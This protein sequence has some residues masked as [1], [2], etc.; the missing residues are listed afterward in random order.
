MEFIKQIAPHAQK[1]QEKY[2]ILASLV[3]AQA[4]LESNF[5]QSGLAQ[6]GKNLFGI[7]GSYNGQSVTMKTTE[8][9]NGKPYKTDAA[10]RKYPSWVESL[11]D[12]AQLYTNGVSW[13]KNKY[14]SIIGETNYVTACK[15][16]QECGYATDPNYAA[17]LI[18]IIEKYE[19]HKYDKVGNKKPTKPEAAAKKE[20]HQVYT[21]KKGDTLSEIAQKYGMT[22]NELVK[23]NNIKNPNLII[24]G[25]VL[26][27][28]AK[29]EK[30]EYYAVK[31]G[32]TLTKI[33]K[34]YET[35][36]QNLVKLNNIKNPDLILVGQ[37][38]RVR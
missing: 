26:K 7:K 15:K 10:F 2:K 32:D 34:K 20:E 18:R 35:T 13:D 36:V 29:T 24:T 28:P 27:V 8:Y 4:C 12:L 23:L 25:Q 22:V 1:I 17:K 33:A 21:V 31:K 30:D 11:E 5:G 16:V 37:K 14:K 19:L 38:L 3:I 6:N 9:R